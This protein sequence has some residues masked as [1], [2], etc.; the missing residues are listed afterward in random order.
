MR[1]LILAA[2]ALTLSACASG[3]ELTLAEE[4]RV[5]QEIQLATDS[6]FAR[7]EATDTEGVFGLYDTDALHADAGALHRVEELRTTYGGI[8]DAYD[9]IE[10]TPARSDIRVLGADA[11]VWIGEGAFRAFQADTV[12][13]SG[14]AAWTIIWER[15]GE[16]DLGWRI[17]HIHQA[18]VVQEGAM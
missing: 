7:A 13:L 10:F 1:I 15:D 14:T 16:S 11:G 6:L 4:Q 12:G 3:G 5:Q 9:R 17:G 8:Y 2:A 18:S